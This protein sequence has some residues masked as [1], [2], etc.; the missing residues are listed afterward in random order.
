VSE[1]SE[2]LLRTV[3]RGLELTL[4]D[5]RRFAA[6][7]EGRDLREKLAKGL[8]F[9]APFVLRLRIIRSTPVGRVL[10]AFGGAALVTKLAKMLRDWEPTV[11]VRT[12]DG[13]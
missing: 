7:P 1:R 9:S 8:M 12:V 6:S 10:G 3:E 11:E 4:A 2:E 13:G 5:V